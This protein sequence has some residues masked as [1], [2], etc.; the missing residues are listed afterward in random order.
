MYFAY[1]Q[2][3]PYTYYPQAPPD[4]LHFSFHFGTGTLDFA[5]W[6]GNWPE[7]YYDFGDIMSTGGAA[8]FANASIDASC[9]YTG[10]LSG[11]D[12]TWLP[13]A[14]YGTP[15]GDFQFVYAADE[16]ETGGGEEA[17]DGGYWV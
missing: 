2:D 5:A 14:T 12:T 1:N 6:T 13:R 8:E 11:S 17:T 9:Y 10:I 7:G 15:Y 3:V 4:P 16:Y